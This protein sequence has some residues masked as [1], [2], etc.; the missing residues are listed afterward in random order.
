MCNV[1]SFGRQKFEFQIKSFVS[2]NFYTF[3]Q[4]NC[5]SGLSWVNWQRWN[6]VLCQISHLRPV[7][8]PLLYYFLRFA[9]PNSW[10]STFSSYLTVRFNYPPR[11]ISFMHYNIM[12]EGVYYTHAPTIFADHLDYFSYYCARTYLSQESYFWACNSFLPK[13]TNFQDQH[14]YSNLVFLAISLIS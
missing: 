1:Y 6:S 2:L 8:V 5:S 4:K 3:S 7:Y 10:C 11:Y 14:P 13:S 9:V 12:H